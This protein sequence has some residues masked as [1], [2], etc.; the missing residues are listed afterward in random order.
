MPIHVAPA[1][2]PEPPLWPYCGSGAVEV[3]DPVGCR[4]RRV[5]PYGEC[6]A[7]LADADRAAYLDGL[8]PGSRLDHRGTPFTGDTLWRLLDRLRDRATG[9][10]R[11]GAAFFKDAV[12]STRAV[13]NGAVFSARTVFDGAVFSA[14]ADFGGAAFSS[15]AGFGGAAFSAGAGFGEV[16]FSGGAVFDEAEF[17]QEAVFRRTRFTAHAGFRQ[18]RFRGNAVFD[19]AVVSGEAAYDGAVFAARAE[20][21]RAV[22]DRAMFRGAAFAGVASFAGSRFAARADFEEAVFAADAGFDRVVFSADGAFTGAAF[23]ARAGFSAAGFE[24]CAGFDRAV[25]SGRAGFDGAVFSGRAGFDA[26]VFAAEAG[27]SGAVFETAARLGPL[28]CRGVLDL[29]GVRFGGP[30]TIEAATTRL[31]CGRTRWESTAALRL[32]YATVDL[33][34]AVI[35]HPVSITAQARPFAGAGET[36]GAEPVLGDA[37][38]GV[39]M[40]SLRGA[41]A[42]HLMLQDIDLSG[43]LLSGTVHLDQ[44][45]LEGDCPLAPAPSRPYR[46]GLLPV[47]PAVRRTLAEEQHWRAA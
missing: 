7:H 5:D 29:S 40:A 25:F 36:D 38:P 20:F 17:S 6:L 26:A 18:T 3:R 24:G 27:F 19:E 12:F 9:E 32:R 43:C 45:R 39:R 1:S 42:A 15:Y 13:F 21:G 41:D 30:V 37:D 23:G 8:V 22:L 31:A 35:D 11:L 14:E 44:L 10:P 2:S 28:T 16:T 4:G 47:W 46:R 33:S 34:D